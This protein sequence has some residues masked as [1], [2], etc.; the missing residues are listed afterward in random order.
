MEASGSDGNSDDRARTVVIQLE[1]EEE[2]STRS[3]QPVTSDNLLKSLSPLIISMR[4]FGLYF[5]RE[6]HVNAEVGSDLTAPGPSRRRCQAWNA[7]RIYAT[8]MLVVSWL[9]AARY[10][11][12]FNGNETVGAALFFKLGIV[13]GVSLNVILRSTYYTASHTGSLDRVFRQEDLCT[14]NFAPKYS[15]VAKVMTIVSWIII[16]SGSVLYI[17][18]MFVGQYNDVLLLFFAK[19][20]PVL[21]NA[22]FLTAI[23]FVFQLETLSAYVLPQAMHI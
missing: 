9:S 17:C 18:M 19:T 3:E 23:F 13:T 20:Y 8:V 2:L 14:A 11:V 5:T 4:A 15:R 7:G 16:L 1:T 6:S 12:I 21:K 10:C 22:I